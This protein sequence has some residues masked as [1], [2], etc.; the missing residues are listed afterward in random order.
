MT[1]P[2]WK[3]IDDPLCYNLAG[4]LKLDELLSLIKKCRLLITVNSLPVHIASALKKPVV[5]VYAKTN[6]QHTPGKHLTRYYILRYRRL[7]KARTGYCILW[8]VL[9]AGKGRRLR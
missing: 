8:R 3:G 6:P 4:Q 5:V 9:T 7:C 2:I 1:Y